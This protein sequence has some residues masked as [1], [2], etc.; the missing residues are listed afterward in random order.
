MTQNYIPRSLDPVLARATEEFPVVVLIGPR[1]IPIEIKASATPRPERAHEI[2]AFQRGFGERARRGYVIH[3]GR[4][5]LPLGEGTLALP[6]AA[7]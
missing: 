7:L 4:T 5:V 6:L 1:Q 2:A 3:P